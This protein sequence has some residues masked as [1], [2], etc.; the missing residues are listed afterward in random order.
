[1]K[2]KILI[3]DDEEHIV[4]FLRINLKNQG[5]D[6]VVAYNGFDG[7]ELAREENPA[8]ILLDIMMPGIDGLETCRRLKKNEVTS[9]IP[10][11]ILSAK[12]E[13]DDKVIGLDIGAEDYIT[14][15]FGIRELFARI[16]KVLSREVQ[17]HKAEDENI[18]QFRNLT[19]DNNKYTVRKDNKSLGLTLTEFRIL[20][21][22]VESKGKVINRSVLIAE[23]GLADTVSGSRA[24]D[25]HM[26]N[27]R[28]KLGNK[29]VYINTIRGVGYM[30]AEN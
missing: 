5:Y 22:L 23:N 9:S 21:T 19:I 6:T 15:P 27:L 14:K 7:I 30:I 1:M 3:I 12:S 25:V 2:K 24:L 16:D 11:I 17:A 8:L 4:D 18:L 10:I 29:E 26:R 13:E 20:K 28:K